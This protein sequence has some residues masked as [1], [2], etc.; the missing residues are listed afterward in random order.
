LS[1]VSACRVDPVDR[2]GD[3]QRSV[4][5]VVFLCIV[6]LAAGCWYANSFETSA[7]FALLTLSAAVPIVF[8]LR[9]GAVGIPMLAVTAALYFIY[10][11]VPLLRSDPILLL[12][13][14]SEIFDAAVS[15][16]LFLGVAIFT[17]EM[18]CLGWPR[19][20]A[21]EDPAERINYFMFIGFGLGMFYFAAVI[22][23]AIAVF[24]PLV[25]LL[26]AV[27]LTATGIASFLLGFA[28]AAGAISGLKRAIAVACLFGVLIM[29][30]S[31]LFL[32]AGGIY[33]GAAI[34]GY[35]VKQRR[36]PWLTILAVCAALFVLNAGKEGMRRKYWLPNANYGADMSIL[37]LP[38]L[39]IEWISEGADA[40]ISGSSYQNV[41]D[42][43][44]LIKLLLIVR[45]VTPERVPYLKGESYTYLPYMLVPR[46]VQSDKMVSQASMILLNIRFGFQTEEGAASTAIGWGLVPEAYANYGN[47]AVAIVGA[48]FG[49]AAGLLNRM[50]AASPVI[51]P[52]TFVAVVAMITALNVEADFSYLITN[53]FQS[54]IAALIFYGVVTFLRNAR[55]ITVGREESEVAHAG[56]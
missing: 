6:L 47:I 3:V 10:Y 37:S 44:S 11:A 32:V 23:G 30:L 27:F 17:C 29:S 48:L 4:V 40:I 2:G 33:I 54:C 41:V 15:V 55:G 5:V 1:G 7:A 28:I 38:T 18:V 24:G 42:R 9:R 31:T 19:N 51:S 36:V 34:L 25:G 39:V 50:S 21:G 43:A 26:R 13:T 53:M 56:N 52:Q 8:W 20:A 46:F 35:V 12:F 14:D 16:A 49:A 45:R 22:V